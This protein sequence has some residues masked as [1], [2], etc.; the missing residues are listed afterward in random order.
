M[1]TF[2]STVIFLEL[3]WSLYGAIY[4]A[5]HQC[6]PSCTFQDTPLLRYQVLANVV[7]IVESL[8]RIGGKH[9]SLCGLVLAAL[10]TCLDKS[11]VR[12]VLD[13]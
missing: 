4:K 9:D 6:K 5:T 11:F 7:Q 13:H 3:A 2:W 1:L 10:A 8:H 12:Y